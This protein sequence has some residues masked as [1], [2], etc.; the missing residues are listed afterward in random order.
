MQAL[1]TIQDLIPILRVSEPTL[2][3]WLSESRKGTGN[4][5]MPINGFKRK[6]LFHPDEIDRW[7]GCRQQSTPV[8]KIESASQRAKRHTAALDRLRQKGVNVP[9]K[10]EDE[11]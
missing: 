8:A 5:P 4:F 2:R 1:L 7:M 3:R 11:A 10:Q 9:V 6:L